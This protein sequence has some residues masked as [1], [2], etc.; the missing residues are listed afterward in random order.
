VQNGQLGQSGRE[1]R[2]VTVE[3]R[4]R[5]GN[6][7]AGRSETVNGDSQACVRSIE[8]WSGAKNSWARSASD[9]NEPEGV[10][11]V[12]SWWRSVNDDNQPEG[13]RSVESWLST[14]NSFVRSASY[15]NNRRACNRSIRGGTVGGYLAIIRTLGKAVLAQSG[16]TQNSTQTWK[17][18]TELDG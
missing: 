12:E 14:G 18:G 2:H 7:G 3:K 11:S 13:M 4:S 15:E 6:D 10:Q 8:H 17:R 9:E 16:V 1:N 5:I